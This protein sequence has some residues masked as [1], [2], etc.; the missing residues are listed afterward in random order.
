[1]YSRGPAKVFISYAREDT[2][3]KD[4]LLEH[5][6]VLKDCGYCEPW[7]DNLIE[8]G[9]KWDK[10]IKIALGK[11]DI[12]LFL[13]SSK[14][15]SS[16]YIKKVEK[17]VSFEREKNEN[18]IIV[19]VILK[20]C[21]W[22][23]S[24][25]GDYEAAPTNGVPISEWDNPNSAYTSIVKRLESLIFSRGLAQKNLEQKPNFRPKHMTDQIIINFHE[26]IV[27]KIEICLTMSNKHWRKI[28][29]NIPLW[30]DS[31]AV[32]YLNKI[33]KEI[34][35]IKTDISGCRYENRNYKNDI[36]KLHDRVRV[37]VSNL[38]LL[39]VDS[40]AVDG[41]LYTRVLCVAEDNDNLKKAV[42]ENYGEGV[43]IRKKIYF[44]NTIPLKNSVELLENEVERIYLNSLKAVS[45]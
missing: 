30:N 41:V 27:R 21:Y 13:T 8:L 39:L 32:V 18:V 37:V 38:D 42:V 16:D 34:R 43:D 44:N 33:L 19:P 20:P 25:L 14:S 3:Y 23:K 35:L 2:D 4:N 7:H 28:D 40:D 36:L 24:K 22:Q 31:Y 1:M 5:L 6:A 12:V 9:Q 29:E 45:N 10:R 15:L 17:A 11:A 26:E